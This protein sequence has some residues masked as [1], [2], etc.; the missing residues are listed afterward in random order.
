MPSP[1]ILFDGDATRLPV[2]LL[3]YL[4]LK[5]TEKPLASNRS[6]CLRSPRK[7]LLGTST[8]MMLTPRYLFA[9]RMCRGLPTEKKTVGGC[10]HEPVGRCFI[11]CQLSLHVGTARH[12]FPPAATVTVCCCVH[13]MRT[14]V[15]STVFHRMECRHATQWVENSHHGYSRTC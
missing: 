6:G 5:T 10:A 1:E 11:I 3:F 2:Q 7:L 9:Q 8:V 12:R 15:Q 4:L 14:V 13:A